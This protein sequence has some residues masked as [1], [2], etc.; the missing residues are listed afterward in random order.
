[1]ALISC[2]ECKKRISDTAAS[3][4][5]CGFRLTPDVLDQIRKRER[6]TK[7]VAG[8]GCGILVLAFVILPLARTPRSASAR[9]V[10]TPSVEQEAPDP[11]PIE[12]FVMSQEFVKRALKAPS[13]AEFPWYEDGFVTR[14]G[15]GRFRVSAYLDAQNSFGAQLRSRYSCVVKS[16]RD[17]SWS[18]E[19]IEIQ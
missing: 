1:M 2:P 14:L 3:C 12:A 11:G 17:G 9:A 4:P 6:K 18:L 7:G 8:V 19:S 16:A 13:T 15:D 10:A 5:G